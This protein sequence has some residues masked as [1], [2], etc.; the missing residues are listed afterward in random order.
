M[1]CEKCGTQIGDGKRVCQK[2]IDS[3]KKDTIIS[4]VVISFVVFSIIFGS[5]LAISTG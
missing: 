2:C 4:I 3:Q 1:F 5:I